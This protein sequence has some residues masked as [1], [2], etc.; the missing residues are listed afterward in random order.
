MSFKS[1]PVISILIF[2]IAF[3]LA[4]YITNSFDFVAT[5][6]W[7]GIYNLIIGYPLYII[8]HI[9]IMAFFFFLFWNI[10]NYI[11]Y[12]EDLGK[13]NEIID[14]Q[15]KKNLYTKTQK[16]KKIKV[17]TNNKILKTSLNK[18]SFR[19]LNKRNS[20]P[21]KTKPTIIDISKNTLTATG[22]TIMGVL[23]I[24]LLIVFFIQ[25]SLDYSD[26]K[27][28]EITFQRHYQ[29]N[30]YND[31]RIIFYNTELE[32]YTQS[33]MHA[34]TNYDIFKS[35]SQQ[36]I[37]FQCITI[38]L[39]EYRE[40]NDSNIADKFKLNARNKY[41]NNVKLISRAYQN[42]KFISRYFTHS[43]TYITDP[44]RDIL[45]KEMPNPCADKVS[46]E[47]IYHVFISHHI[48]LISE[49]IE[50]RKN[51]MSTTNNK[52]YSKQK[53]NNLISWLNKLHAHNPQYQ[54]K[55]YKK[56]KYNSYLQYGRGGYDDSL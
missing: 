29:T 7:T 27:N 38:L 22:N 36:E 53:V 44:I 4:R 3:I 35:F 41:I 37:A 24:F 10:V 55:K 25:Y 43:A 52:N 19:Y 39:D 42:E 50:N 26:S 15:D 28:H 40:N 47:K 54:K 31:S 32:N 14:K 13:D 2:L 46:I 18:N 48:K 33:F 8:V 12:E 30:D 6:G 17:F 34:S 51:N 5:E 1:K 45:R 23:F 21:T 56:Y 9:G 16:S 20:T 11:F 49:Q